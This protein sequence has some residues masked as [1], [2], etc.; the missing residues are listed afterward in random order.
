MSEPAA[1]RARVL[2]HVPKLPALPAEPFPIDLSRFVKM[3]VDPWATPALSSEQKTTLLANIQL[4]RDAIVTF[5][6]C[7]SK[8]GY[9]GHTGGAYDTVPEVLLMD[10][11][12][13]AR[14]DKFVPIH[15]DEAG[16][17]VATQYLLSVLHGDL[18]AR[19]LQNY[20]KGHCLLPGH[21][22]IG[23]TP[24]V[25]F[26]SG[27]LG[28][29]WPYVNGVSMAEPGKV[30]FCLGSDGSQME[31]DDSEAARLAVS[32]NL[33]VKLVIDDNDVT[34]AG[35]PSDYFKGYNVE[36]TLEGHG[37]PCTVVQGEQ[38]DALYAAIRGAVV[39]DGPHAVVCKRPM[40]PGITGVEGTTHGHDA[41]AVGN[42]E[43]YFAERGL[44]DAD[45][46]VKG[47]GKT[48]DPHGAYLGSG[49]TRLSNRNIFGQTLV[50]IF[51]GMDKA[52]LKATVRCID[53]DL[54][55]SVGFKHIRAAHPAIYVKSGIME[56]GNFS[57]AAGFG[58]DSLPG[59]NRQG[60]FSTFAAF[61]EMCASEFTMARLNR[62]NVLCHFS[63]SGVDDMADN[64]CHF[65]LNAFFADNGLDDQY[66]TR[67]YF[68]ADGDQMN[69]V[70]RRVFPDKGMR[71]IFSTRS[72]LPQILDAASGKPMFGDGY[73]FVPGKDE[74]VREGSA[75]YIVSFGDALY[76]ALDAVERLRRDHGL[77]VGLI[78]KPTLNVADDAMLAKIGAAKFVLVVESLSQKNGLGVRMGSWLLSRGLKPDYAYL[79]TH[80]E[81]CGGLW[82]QAY[83]QGYDS[84]SIVKKVQ[85][86]AARK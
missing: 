35:H 76:R 52:V 53:S 80:R 66:E 61:L 55:G 79:G 25:K 33:N 1:K 19:Y 49:E 12:F 31:G 11:F 65:G 23:L 18:D 21:P 42:A 57:A 37:V 86:L 4:C 69:A 44:G 72:K 20:R 8:S 2:E 29:M 85:E 30:V 32:E 68:P 73:K 22:E 17:R 16:H 15:F 5:T 34:I 70:V 59:P 43:K 60:I 9:G 46:Y 47:V 56:R 75:G 74:L 58:M 39:T 51:D 81:G 62:S 77:E 14:P 64:T 54:E 45:A 24:G 13:Q 38:L 71:F 78:N 50:K 10:A 3:A 41:V 63:H 26:S 36:K 27:R 84:D 48:A 82:E 67:L 28:H 40:C 7:G 83:H 6:A